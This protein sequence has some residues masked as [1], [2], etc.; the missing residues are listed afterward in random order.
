[1]EE[2]ARQRQLL[3]LLALLLVA[4]LATA[5]A[6]GGDGDGGGGG[7]NAEA[8]PPDGA[9]PLDARARG[10]PRR[11]PATEGRQLVRGSAR[12]VRNSSDPLHN[13]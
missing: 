3:L 13:R 9:T 10:W 2:M 1:M 7:G 6:V 11:L 5:V 12:R 8:K 4:L